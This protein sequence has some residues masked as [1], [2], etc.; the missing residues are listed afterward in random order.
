[1]PKTSKLELDFYR[2][3]LYPFLLERPVT[4]KTIVIFEKVLN[5]LL[6]AKSSARR[7]EYRERLEKI[8][9]NLAVQSEDL[10]ELKLKHKKLQKKYD[11]LQEKH[12]NMFQA[13]LKT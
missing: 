8:I 3:R 6:K 5:S 9:R 2:K 13:N 10:I 7:K 1:M 4:N 12:S 11:D